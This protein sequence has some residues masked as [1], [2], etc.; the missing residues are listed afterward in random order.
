MT[1][2]DLDRQEREA[3]LSWRRGL[4][5]LA[6]KEELLLTPFERNIEVWRQ[7]WRVL[8]RSQLVVQIVDARNPLRFRCED[9]EAYVADIEGPEGEKDSG[10][11]KPGSRKSLLLVNKADLLTRSQRIKW[12]DY[13]DANGVKFAFYSA[14][15]AAA[16][17][18]QER[19]F[20][21]TTLPEQQQQE[22][23]DHPGDSDDEGG[24]QSSGPTESED[25]QP[26]LD[27]GRGG[28][29]SESEDDAKDETDARIK[30]LTV[31]ELEELFIKSAPPLSGTKLHALPLLILT[32]FRLC[33]L[34]GRSSNKTDRRTGRLS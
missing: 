31:K 23:A 29:T 30:V 34:Q 14:M 9:L 10:G 16:L 11:G 5:D 26:S 22:T 27:S 33:R 21:S 4:A 25:E 1:P 3:F 17:L 2:I 8:E 15:D 32:G 7:L 12:A 24:S 19:P 28:D 20:P 13:F 18:E 6:E